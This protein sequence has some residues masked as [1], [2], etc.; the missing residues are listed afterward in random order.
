[1]VG[2]LHHVIDDGAAFVARNRRLVPRMEG[3]RRVAVP[4][5]PDY[6]VREALANALAHRDWSL[7]GAKVRLF[8]FDDRLEIWSPGRLPAPITLERLGYDQAR[9][10]GASTC[11]SP[12]CRNARRRATWR[13]SWS[14]TYSSSAAGAVG[15]GPTDCGRTAARNRASNRAIDGTITARSW[16]DYEGTRRCAPPDAMVNHSAACATPPVARAAVRQPAGPGLAARR[17]PVK[18]RW[19]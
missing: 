10:S 3:I 14:G 6:S 5:Y 12:T 16:P 1:M 9:S 7:E 11:G 2:P 13:T 19:S 18:R 15:A 8:L 17:S 4:E